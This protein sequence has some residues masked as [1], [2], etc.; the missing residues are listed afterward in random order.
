MVKEKFQN[1]KVNNLDYKLKLTTQNNPEL[2]KDARGIIHYEQLKIF[3][4]KNCAT[5]LRIKTF[6]HELAHALCEASSFNNALMES[7]EDDNYEIFIDN[8]GLAIEN[9]IHNNNIAEIE[10]FIKNS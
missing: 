2:G 3:L 8:L 4:D 5:Q 6:Y 1:V 9:F 7:L 10:S